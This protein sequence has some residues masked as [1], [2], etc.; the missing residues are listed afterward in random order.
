M[1]K[2]I[3]FIFMAI[4]AYFAITGCSTDATLP[5]TTE[6]VLESAERAADSQMFT[7]WLPD[8]VTQVKAE[9]APHLLLQETII[10]YYE[11]PEEYW[12]ETKYYY[13]YV[14]LDNDGT[15]EIFAVL[16]GSFVSGSG[17]NSALWCEERDGTMQIRQAF[18]LV[19]TPILVTEDVIDVPN[20]GA[21]GLLLQRSGGGGETEI[22]Q[23]TCHN[24]VF[25]NVADAEPV[26]NIED[27][28]GTAIICNDLV[29]DMETGNYLTLAQ[30]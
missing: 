29:D 2:K 25:L 12:D 26:D 22:V 20:G 28:R 30:P 9:T 17:G 19:N 4:F 24:G 10:D 23:L 11:I 13:N 21:K 15:N 7:G 6:N 27:V 18:T 3:A 8:Q 14:D 5:P 16:L 1:K